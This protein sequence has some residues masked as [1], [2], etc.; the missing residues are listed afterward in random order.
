MLSQRCQ[1]YN[2]DVRASKNPRM[3]RNFVIAWLGLGLLGAACGREQAG[4]AEGSKTSEEAHWLTD[5]DLAQTQARSQ[6]RKLLI[7]FTGSDWCPPCIMLHR[8]IFSQPELSSM[9]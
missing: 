1:N 7:N 8:Q 6:N 4:Q 5:F 2:E 9:P 3:N